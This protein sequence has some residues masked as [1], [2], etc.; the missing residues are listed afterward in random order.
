[1]HKILIAIALAFTAAPAFAAMEALE[2][3]P[4]EKDLRN[5]PNGV[6]APEELAESQIYTRNWIQI[7][8]S[9]T[10]PEIVTSVLFGDL[11]TL[12]DCPVRVAVVEDGVA[13]ALVPSRF[14]QFAYE[15]ACQDLSSYQIDV[16]AGV[17]VACG[18]VILF[19]EEP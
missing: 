2:F 17:L 12:R 18:V 4:P 8:R 3:A 16:E 13:A 5:D 15:T 10:R 9:A 1:M 14:D 19:G 6:W 7:A 11:C